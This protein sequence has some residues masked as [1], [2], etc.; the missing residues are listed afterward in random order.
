[1]VICLFPH[2]LKLYVYMHFASGVN[3]GKIFFH[4]E[5]LQKQYTSYLIND[6][7]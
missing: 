6:Q 7:A 4:L 3:T 1:M 2:M 5:H